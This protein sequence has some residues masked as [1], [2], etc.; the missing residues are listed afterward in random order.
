MQPFLS[1]QY[2]SLMFEEMIERK[3]SFYLC[4]KFR[5]DR[6]SSFLDY[7]GHSGVPLLLLFVCCRATL[8]LRKHFYI[9]N[10]KV[11]FYYLFR[12]ETLLDKQNITC[13]MYYLSLPI[14]TWPG[15]INLKKK[16]FP[17]ILHANTMYVCNVN[18][19]FH[20]NCETPNI[21]IYMTFLS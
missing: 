14:A 4:Y 13:G 11:D 16:I 8:L 2:L 10:L 20:L 15:Q 19:A 21:Y 3:C 5:R 6:L 12:Y 7:L 9:F 1:C 17:H 18:E